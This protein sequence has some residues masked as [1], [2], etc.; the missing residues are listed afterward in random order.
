MSKK[1]YEESNIEDIAD[2]IREKNGTQ[3]TYRVAEMPTAIRNIVPVG[4]FIPLDEKGAAEGVAELD[5][6]GKVPEEQLPEIAP[7]TE[8][9]WAEYQALSEA[10]KN[11]GTYYSIIDKDNVPSGVIQSLTVTENGTYNPPSG[12]DGYAPV[13]VNVS[14]SILSDYELLEYIQSDGTQRIESDISIPT[15]ANIE[16]LYEIINYSSSDWFTAFGIKS[17]ASGS[18]AYISINHAVNSSKDR[19]ITYGDNSASNDT[20]ILNKKYYISFVSK[21][22]S[23][24]GNKLMIFADQSGINLAQIALYALSINNQIFLPC[25]RKSDGVCGLFDTVNRLFLTDKL[26]GNPFVAGP[27]VL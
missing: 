18:I 24:S 10:E 20:Y 17:S 15:G 16:I 7:F 6:N 1:L 22:S 3:T 27:K 2:A 13:T 26:D 19:Y 14:G 11:N 9:T 5:V 12:V 4:D 25:R 8:L 23:A 21:A